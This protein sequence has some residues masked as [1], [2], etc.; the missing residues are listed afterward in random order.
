M[1]EK[2]SKV[3]NPLSPAALFQQRHAPPRKQQVRHVYSQLHFKKRIRPSLTLERKRMKAA[4]LTEPPVN[5]VNRITKTCWDAESEAFQ[6]GLYTIVNDMYETASQ[7]YTSFMDEMASD[8]FLAEYVL[9]LKS[10]KYGAHL[11]FVELSQTLQ[12]TFSLLQSCSA[13]NTADGQSAFSW[14]GPFQG[15]VPSGPIPLGQILLTL[16]GKRTWFILFSP[17]MFS[18]YIQCS[19]WFCG[20]YRE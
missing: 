17:N 7:T 16:L 3:Q 12:I 1:V 8:E 5:T 20:G 10:V 13:R 4:G 2:P 18:F 15:Q 6:Q 14:L 11:N 19:R 9:S